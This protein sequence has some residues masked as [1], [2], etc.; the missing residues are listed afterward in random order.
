MTFAL[1]TYE[2]V[3]FHTYPALM[4]AAEARTE[5][6]HPAEPTHRPEPGVAA[7]APVPDKSVPVVAYLVGIGA[8]TVLRDQ[9]ADFLD[10]A[11]VRRDVRV[12]VGVSSGSTVEWVLRDA[13]PY[14][15]RALPSY[16][17]D[18]SAADPQAALEAAGAV[19][20]DD[21]SASPDRR[22]VVLVWD[23]P[24]APVRLPGSL[25][26]ALVLHC[27]DAVLDLPPPDGRGPCWLLW[28]SRPRP[29]RSVLAQAGRLLTGWDA[30]TEIPDG[31]VLTRLG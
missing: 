24:P 16:P 14:G 9:L 22:L 23:R 25:A 20:A 7:A 29:P 19:L 4:R 5:V 27:V 13:V 28:R 17:P 6:L 18:T 21:A 15:V 10:A 1:D 8:T 3:A 26:S 12:S 30:F 2:P 11:G 31:L